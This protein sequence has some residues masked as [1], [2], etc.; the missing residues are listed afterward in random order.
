M[1]QGWHDD[2]EY[3]D[4]AVASANGSSDQY[5]GAWPTV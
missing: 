5:D 1:E 2:D 3:G 4:K